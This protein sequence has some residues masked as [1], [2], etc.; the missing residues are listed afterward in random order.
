MIRINYKKRTLQESCDQCAVIRIKQVRMYEYTV[1][2]IRTYC[3][4]GVVSDAG[5]VGGEGSL[6][7]GPR[8]NGDGRLQQDVR[9]YRDTGNTTFMYKY[10]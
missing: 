6:A 5:R 3:S 2:R 1:Y 4:V 9:L 8:H 7:G 10:I